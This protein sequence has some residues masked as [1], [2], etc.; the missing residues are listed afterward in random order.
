MRPLFVDTGAWA[1]ITDFRDANHQAALRFPA[2][3][4]GSRVLIVTDYVINESFTLLLRNLGYGRTTAFQRSL[5]RLTGA[6]I[7]TCVWVTPEIAEQAW[8]V[9]E[10]FNVDKLWAFTDCVSYAVMK[11][12]GIV[13]AFAFDRHFAQIG[14]VRV[15]TEGP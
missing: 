15:P 11:Q 6:G 12:M 1:A 13:E 10:R 5:R 4:A 14:F 9:F 3:I 7:V 2:E 8:R